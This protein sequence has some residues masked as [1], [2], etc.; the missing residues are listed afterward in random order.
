MN[1]EDGVKRLE[2]INSAL[3]NPKTKFDEA[4][5]LFDEALK[6]TKDCQNQI[7]KASGKIT[8][9]TIGEEGIIES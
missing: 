2:E 6:I 5:K 3:E 4:M 7:S 8:K 9:I 1:F